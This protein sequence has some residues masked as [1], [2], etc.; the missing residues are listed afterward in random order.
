M[1]LVTAANGGVTAASDA[2][3]LLV[4]GTYTIG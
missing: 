3:K 1:Y 2:V 4:R